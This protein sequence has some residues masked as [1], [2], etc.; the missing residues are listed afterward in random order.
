MEM[1]DDLLSS[2]LSDFD[3]PTAEV[4][5][6]PILASPE[7]ATMKHP[8]RDVSSLRKLA[9]TLTRGCYFGD[10]C[11]AMSS[12]SGRGTSALDV[13]KL[14]E[15]REIVRKRAKLNDMAFENVWHQC[16]L[17]ISK[18]CQALRKGTL[19]KYTVKL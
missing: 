12:P 18:V 3:V 14:H 19:K 11:L 10:D 5:T 13:K 16:L 17:S 2:L 15:I 1:D 6:E 9:T 8:G 4:L 7:K